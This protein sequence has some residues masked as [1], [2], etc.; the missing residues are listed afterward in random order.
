MQKS[1]N[2]F[3]VLAVAVVAVAT[4]S[5]CGGGGS[6][7]DG[8]TVPVPP[9]V[10]EPTPD[11]GPPPDPPL[12]ASCE[13]LPLGDPN[14]RCPFEAPT[15]QD[16]VDNAIRT[17]QNEQ[18]D[19]FDQNEVVQAVGAYY[20]G[21]IQI[22][23]RQGLCAYYDGEELGVSNSANFNDQF[24]ILTANN[25]M[26]IGE[27]TYR[28]TCRPSAIPVGKGPLPP[29]PEGCNLAPSRE[30]ACSRQVAGQFHHVVENAVQEVMDGQPELFNFNDVANGNGPRILD[31][32]AYTLAVVDRIRARGLCAKNDELEEIALKNENSFSEQYDIQFQD[33]Y[34]RTG[35]GIY[36]STCYPAAF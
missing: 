7:N 8:P 5:V 27:K 25:R 6:S 10:I 12:S 2:H 17:L 13:A 11:P 3:V 14:V 30:V 1:W 33:K 15:F 18:P 21:L 9:P 19:L 31:L 34:V 35:A 36:R 26:R 32:E 16:E 22:L 29:S 23:D 4:F 28:S 24:D 20:V